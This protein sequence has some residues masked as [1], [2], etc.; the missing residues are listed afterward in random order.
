MEF[1]QGFAISGMILIIVIL[2]S[3]F[4]AQKENFDYYRKTYLAL[5]SGEYTINCLLNYLK[6]TY[7]I[8]YFYTLIKI[9]NEEKS[10]TFNRWL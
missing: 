1:L 3:S 7:Q 4:M 9:K 6:L 10:F 2:F 8:I 5:T